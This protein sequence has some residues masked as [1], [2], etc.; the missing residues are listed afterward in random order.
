MA[1][2]LASDLKVYEPEI[3]SGLYEGVAQAI[4]G[5]VAGS[6]GAINIRSEL[7]PGHY[8]KAAFTD[9]SLTVSRRDVTSQSTLTPAVITQDENVWVKVNRTTDVKAITLDSAKKAGVSLE[10]FFFILGQQYAEVKLQDMINTGLIAVETAIQSVGL[11]HDATTGS[12]TAKTLITTDLV[13]GLAKFG[14]RGGDIVAWAMH[15]KP[16]YDLVKE[17]VGA[18]IFGN[19]D[20]VIY[21]GTA[22]TF[23][24]PVIVTDAPALTDANGSATDTY[25]VLGLTRN[26]LSVV[27]SEPD[28]LVVGEIEVASVNMYRPMKAEFAYSLGVRGMKYDVTD[29]VNPSDSTLGTTGAWLKAVASDKHTAGVRIVCQ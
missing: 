20:V 15:S 5:I 10:E 19:A 27:E 18:K 23:G 22:G 14:D 25:N 21:G 2:T 1:I 11:T 24:R 7:L 26:A 13:D 28:S 3:Q 29:G 8:F 9:L 17:Q 4:N 16:F 12:A 6:N